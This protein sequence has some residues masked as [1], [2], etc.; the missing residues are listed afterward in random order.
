MF[1]GTF[2]ENNEYISSKKGVV[3]RG[4]NKLD[5]IG[6]FDQRCEG[7]EFC[8]NDNNQSLERNRHLNSLSANIIL[9]F[10]SVEA[11]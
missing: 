6:M 7:K 2:L 3:W 11:F 5:Y 1:Q 8:R 4:L 10:A 9:I